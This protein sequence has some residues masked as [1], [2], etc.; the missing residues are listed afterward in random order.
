L[1]GVAG[2]AGLEIVVDRGRGVGNGCLPFPVG[3]AS[4]SLP[5]GS[6]NRHALGFWAFLEYLLDTFQR[7]TVTILRTI[8][9]HEL[10]AR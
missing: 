6:L 10:V 7:A 3:A 4:S 2:L 1:G 8:G 5:F 9:K